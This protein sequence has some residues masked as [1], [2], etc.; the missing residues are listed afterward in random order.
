MTNKDF[1]KMKYKYKPHPLEEYLN[2]AE[3]RIKK[4]SSIK[5]DLISFAEE[6]FYVKLEDN[7][8]LLN[9]MA[10]LAEKYKYSEKTVR[11]IVKADKEKQTHTVSDTV[12]NKEEQK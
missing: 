7:Q 10:K 4:A 6:A 12:Q 9:K 11:R 2:Y 8:K 3:E 1:I 5:A